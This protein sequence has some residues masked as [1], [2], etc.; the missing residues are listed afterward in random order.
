M[1]AGVS[2]S[3]ALFRNDKPNLNTR[4][5]SNR[6]NG[7]TIHRRRHARSSTPRGYYAVKD[8]DD[9]RCPV[10]I[11]S[12]DHVKAG[13]DSGAVRISDGRWLDRWMVKK[14]VPM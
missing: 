9:I 2:Q 8:L 6:S 10:I 13:F 14:S 12:T 7:M 4:L 1:T 5:V 3:R 11:V